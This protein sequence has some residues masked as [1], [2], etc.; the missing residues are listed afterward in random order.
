MKEKV[1]LILKTPLLIQIKTENYQYVEHM[2]EE[3]TR[4]VPN[5]Q[6]MPQFR[7]GIWN[8]KACM[9]D[10]VGRTFPYGIMFD[11]IRVHRKN[12]PDID[13]EVSKK[14]RDLFINDDEFKINYDL[15][16]YPR[17]YQ[18]DCIESCLKYKRGIIRSATASGKSLVIG[19]VI[20]HLF[21][22]YPDF[23]KQIIIVP[24]TTLIRQFH[25]N[26]VEYGFEDI[27]IGEVHAKSKEWDKKI[28]IST[29]Q[30]LSRV[31]KKLEEFDAIYVDETHG[32]KA[33]QLKKTLAKAGN[34]EYRI[35][36]TGTLHAND[37]DNW[38]TKAFLGPIIRE[39][40]AGLLAEEGWISKCV[41]NFL[42]IEYGDDRWE[43]NYNEVK[44]QIF[45]HP[46]RNRLVKDICKIVDHNILLLV[47]KVEKEGEFL[48]DYLKSEIK[49]KEIVFIS[50]RDS[51]E[52]REKWRKAC[53]K[54][55]DIILI[56]TYGI[57][58]QGIDI[59]NLKYVALVAPF[60][61]KIRVLQ[62]IGRALRKHV[63]KEQGAQIFDLQDDTRYFSDYGPIRLRY[64]DQEK[65]EINEYLLREKEYT[66]QDILDIIK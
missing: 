30:S 32:A 31:R 26:L 17:P 38:N 52:V 50:G 19:Y 49:N 23:K 1:K 18:K 59:P 5:F 27:D 40:S 47:G 9:I 21:D 36:F 22:N 7:S 6:Y 20:K 15:S 43:G 56:A 35:G 63:N 48:E 58:Q 66:P 62:S 14:V 64:Y 42:N 24:N 28:V 10:K 12:F 2:R 29:W 25:E 16:L 39:Y 65:F 61:S 51:V 45:T 54:R 33:F 41:V 55:K 4:L 53:G 37:L 60:K 57:F 8:G 3:F 46:Y 44:E 13:I 11:Y 34:A